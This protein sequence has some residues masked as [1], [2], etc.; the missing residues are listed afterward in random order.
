MNNTHVQVNTQTGI[1]P[2]EPALDDSS[3]CEMVKSWRGEGRGGGLG[4]EVCVSVCLGGGMCVYM[5][6][7]VCV[8]E[9][10][11]G[12]GMLGNNCLEMVQK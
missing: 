5:R 2:R 4:H 3:R 6:V 10:G 9:G 11:E 1:T 8:Y 7:C 12:R